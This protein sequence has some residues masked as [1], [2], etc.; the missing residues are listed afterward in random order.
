M[1]ESLPTASLQEIE[2]A[3]GRAWDRIEAELLQLAPVLENGPTKD[4]GW[5]TR[6]LLSHIVGSW[7]R[8]PLHA[9]FFLEGMPLAVEIDNCFWTPE[10]ETAPLSAFRMCLQAAFD[11][12]KALLHRLEPG[13]LTSE[14]DTPFG[15]FAL[16]PFLML[17]Y[18]KHM[19]EYHIPQLEALVA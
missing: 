10:W 7:Q 9:S 3:M 11:G 15:R 16:G 5:S 13:D 8:V 2:A 18:E 4:N 1:A 12:N 14:A 17:S 6:E 19:V